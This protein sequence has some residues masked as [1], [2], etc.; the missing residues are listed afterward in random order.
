MVK[1]KSDQNHESWV[2]CHDSGVMSHDLAVTS[3]PLN[4]LSWQ[5]SDSQDI[6]P[7]VTVYGKFVCLFICVSPLLV[8]HNNQRNNLHGHHEPCVTYHDSRVMN[9]VIAVTPITPKPV[10]QL[11]WIFPPWHRLTKWKFLHGHYETWVIYHDSKV[12][13]YNLAI[14]P[15]PVNQ[16]S[17]N[18]VWWHIMTKRT[19]GMVVMPQES[20]VMT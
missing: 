17:W 12:M 7:A 9:H 4:H 10:N 3:E 18:F 11:N 13:N 14:T 16:L 5:F 15:K 20:Q 2:T 19:I 1:I 6:V 8:V